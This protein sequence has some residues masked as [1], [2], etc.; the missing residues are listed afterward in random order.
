MTTQI[1]NKLFSCLC[2]VMLISANSLSQTATPPAAG[3]GSEGSPYEIATLENL[4]WLSQDI[5][6][7]VSFNFCKLCTLTKIS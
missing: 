2:I 1:I 7:S 4:C 5:V 6:L 3:N